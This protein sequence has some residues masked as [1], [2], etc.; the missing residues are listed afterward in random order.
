VQNKSPEQPAKPP[1]FRKEEI[2]AD[3]KR[4]RKYNNYLT[5]GPGYLSSSIR[6]TVQ[7]AVG[8]DFQFHIRR[9]HFQIG[10]LMSGEEF[11]SNNNIQLKLGYGY[12]REKRASNLA[13]FI[14]PTYFTGVEG[15][16]GVTAASFYNGFGAYACLQA[17]AKFTY[18][19]GFGLEAFAEISYKQSMAGIK[20]VFFFS[21]AYRGLKRNYNPN[22]R[23]ENPR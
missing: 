6:K 14:G 1:Y 20:A 10:V 16:P 13:A 11:L 23:S 5:A 17:I 15:T 7:K 19:I 8:I 4:Y 3:G 22:V 21:G 9:E 12:R 18:D 2:L